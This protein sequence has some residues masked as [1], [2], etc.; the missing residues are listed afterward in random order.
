[1]EI[2]TFFD[3]ATFTLTHVIY[4][5]ATGD[6]VV[7]DPVLDFDPIAWSLHESSLTRLNEFITSKKLRLHYVVDTHIHADHV[8]GMQYFKERYSVPLVINAAISKVQATFKN[9][10]DMPEKFKADGSQFD[11]LVKDGD[12]LKAGS[13]GLT[14]MTT[15][16]HTPACTTYKVGDAMF[17]G[18]AIFCPDVG[19]G[20][21]D[22]PN[23]SARDLYNSITKKIY[24]QADDTKIFPGH[25]Y[26]GSRQ[27]QVQTTVG[28][29]KKRN[30]DLP[31]SRSERDYVSFMEQRDARLPNPKLI[32]QGVQLNINAGA[33]PEP[34]ANGMSYLK[35]PIKKA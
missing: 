25:D 5:A 21:C 22:F 20:R 30:A 35:I 14:V 28:E 13:L 19:T 4:D 17:T 8:T 26:P 31:A 1:M 2:K 16:G 6:A 7:I 3:E 15:P 34:E 12:V 33:M 27:L 32:Y 24:T 23:G 9:I 18:D 10:F 11:L 29:N